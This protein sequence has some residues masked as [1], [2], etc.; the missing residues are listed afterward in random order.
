[1]RIDATTMPR[2]G[3]IAAAWACATTLGGMTARPARALVD[4]IPLYAPGEEIALP[5]YGFE[6]QLPQ[7]E[8]LRDAYLP[9]VRQALARDDWAVAQPAMS[10]DAVNRQL[11]VLGRTASILGDEAY[12]ALNLKARYSAVAKRLQ[13]SLASAASSEQALRELSELDATL[14]EFIALIPA[15]VV[16][17]VRE[18][19][20]KR[21]AESGSPQVVAEQPAEGT[22]AAEAAATPQAQPAPP[23]AAPVAPGGLLFTPSREQPVCGVNIRC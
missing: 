9:R 20:R 19:E 22:A 12:S 10:A 15:T 1:M 14:N 4:G 7:L 16:D 23:A 5:K 11:A 17:A 18:R 8:M 3:A 6:T 2:R 21:R 13:G